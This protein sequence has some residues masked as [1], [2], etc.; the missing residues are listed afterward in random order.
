MR[1]YA[2]SDDALPPPPAPVDE[3]VSGSMLKRVLTAIA[4]AIIAAAIAYVLLHSADGRLFSTADAGS[5]ANTLASTTA[6][7]MPPWGLY[8]RDLTDA[9]REERN[10]KNG[11][12]VIVA[13]G[14]SAIA[15]VKADDVIM[16][17]DD[18]AVRN[19]DEFWNVAAAT[20][21]RFALGLRRKDEEIVIKIGS[22][23]GEVVA[24][25]SHV[26]SARV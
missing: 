19:V 6:A 26:S 20:N 18:K 11:I 8:L 13:V 22:A 1:I 24:A 4:A 16:K 23:E 14:A 5:Q 3:I 15:G 17:V 7:R 2:G 9:E 12:L 10:V 21:G 25:A